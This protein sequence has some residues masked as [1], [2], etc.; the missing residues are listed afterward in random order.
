[1]VTSKLVYALSNLPSPG[2]E[3]WKTVENCL[4]RFI[5]DDKNDMTS[6]RTRSFMDTRRAAYATGIIAQQ[7]A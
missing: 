6:S 7:R 3:F 5:Y 2:N 4:Y 1:M